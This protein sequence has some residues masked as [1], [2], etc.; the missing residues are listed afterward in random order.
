MDQMRH[1]TEISAADNPQGNQSVQEILERLE[2][3]RLLR[4]TLATQRDRLATRLQ[5][6][7]SELTETRHRLEEAATAG[8]NARRELESLWRSTS[9]RWTRPLRELGLVVRRLLRGDFWRPGG[10]E[11]AAPAVSTAALSS[12]AERVFD[13]LRQAVAESRQ[14]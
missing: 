8:E 12:D 2:Q 3:E 10:A 5:V 14:D 9:W 11:Q 13:E 4:E 1:Q 6:V 7:Q